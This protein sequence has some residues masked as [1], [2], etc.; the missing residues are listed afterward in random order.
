MNR[1][2]RARDN[3]PRST[4]LFGIARWELTDIAEFDQLIDGIPD[5]IPAD[6]EPLC[7]LGLH[8]LPV[9]RFAAQIEFK[10]PAVDAASD[11]LRWCRA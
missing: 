9:A 2:G 7:Q 1:T 8:H 11:G 3:R 10:R 4:A 5:A 6:L